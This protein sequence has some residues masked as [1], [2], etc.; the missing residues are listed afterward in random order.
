MVLKLEYSSYGAET[1]IL[2]KVDEKYPE[3]FEMWCRRRVEKI[4]WANCVRNE[5]L[6]RVEAE[7]IIIQTIQEG[8]LIGLVICYA[9]S[10]S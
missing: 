4:S 8:R 3:G 2:K 7:R 9:G 5:V 1:W 10:A 6:Q